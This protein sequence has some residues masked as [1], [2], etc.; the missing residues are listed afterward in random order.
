MILAA[1]YGSRL[2]PLTLTTPKPLVKFLDKPVLEYAL[3]NIMAAGISDIAIN[4]S[5]L[6]EK[7]MN[8]VDNLELPIQ[9]KVFSENPVPFGSAGCY[10]A[11]DQWREKRDLLVVNGD[12]IFDFCLKSLLQVHKEFSPLATLGILPEQGPGPGQVFMQS[13]KVQFIG[14]PNPDSPEKNQNATTV[15]GF[16]GIQILSD[17]FLEQIPRAIPSEII[18]FYQELLNQES[19]VIGK[20]L[21]GFWAD[22]GSLSS[23]HAAQIAWLGKKTGDFRDTYCESDTGS[24]DSLPSFISKRAFVHPQAKIDGGSIV[25]KNAVI[26]AGV[27]IKNSLVYENSIIKAHQTIQNRLV[28]S[29]TSIQLT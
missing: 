17:S 18:P 19:L 16:T 27:H 25:L 29:D 21:N 15:H 20:K 11:L 8:Y 22:I 28:T 14:K 4:C 23:L 24:S 2:R 1:G 3:K 26:E 13:D 5:Y 10:L 12:L 9:I 6:G 7:I